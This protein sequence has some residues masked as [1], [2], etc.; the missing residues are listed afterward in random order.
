MHYIEC[1]DGITDFN[2][3]KEVLTSKNLIVKEYEQLY[4]VKYDKSQCDMN[5]ND[6]KKCRGIVLE[7]GTNKLVC[8]PPPKAEKAEIFSED[9]DD[10]EYLADF[11]GDEDYLGDKEWARKLRSKA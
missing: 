5:D 6:I 10:F 1:L 8:V 2:T 7:K 9:S 4:M 3:S 11:V